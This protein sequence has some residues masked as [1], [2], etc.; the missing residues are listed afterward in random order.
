VL[1]KVLKQRVKASAPEGIKTEV[2][3]YVLRKV[4]KQR[5][6]AYAPEGIKTEG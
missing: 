6:K 4:L 2:L 3:R 1:R 5:V